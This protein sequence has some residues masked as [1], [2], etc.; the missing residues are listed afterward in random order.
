MG[1]G[2]Q[3][4]WLGGTP[5]W[6]FAMM[7]WPIDLVVHQPFRWLL[8]TRVEEDCRIKK[9]HDVTM[10]PSTSGGI[11]V[12]DEVGLYSGRKVSSSNV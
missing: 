11:L 12:T 8:T 2:G 3:K 7:S 4:T 10:N 5:E 1:N 6:L 9:E